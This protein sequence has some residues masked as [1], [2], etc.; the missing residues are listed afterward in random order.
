MFKVMAF[1]IGVLLVT[2]SATA[3]DRERLVGTWKV[4]SFDNVGTE[5]ESSRIVDNAWPCAV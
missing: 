1:A 4:I 2:Q 5:S 3:D